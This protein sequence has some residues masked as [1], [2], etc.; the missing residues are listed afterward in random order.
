MA[1]LRQTLIGFFDARMVEAELAVP[2]A[3]QGR[4]ATVYEAVRV[5]SEDYDETGT[6]LRVRGLPETVA[7]L[8]AAFTR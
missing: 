7:R 5:L 8:R 4:I 3:E 2:Y 6:R 1:S